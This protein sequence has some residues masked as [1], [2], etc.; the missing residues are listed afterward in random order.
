VKV[1]HFSDIHVQVNYAAIPFARLGWRR[2]LAQ[3]E[4][5]LLRR[6]NKFKD[7]AATVRRIVSASQEMQVDYAVLSGDLTGLGMP[8]EFRAAREALGPLAV[9]ERLALVPGNHDRFTRDDVHAFDDVFGDLCVSDMPEHQ[10]AGRFPYVRLVGTELAVIALDTS[11]LAPFPGF[12]FG[13]VR[14]PQFDALKAILADSRL[15]GRAVLVVVHHAPRTSGGGCDLPTHRL[16]AA[17]RLMSLIPG[18]RHAL[19]FGHIHQRYWH[20]ATDRSPH[21]FGA[22]SSTQAGVT[23][24]WIIEIQ[25]GLVTDAHPVTLE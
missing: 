19:L 4:F 15:A 21:L 2:S 5:R 23:G 18:P 12:V 9:P 25:G 14:G 16:L 10:L 17:D 7:A 22:G 20:R 11:Q 24:Y 3:V 6:A 1:L 8:E 13:S